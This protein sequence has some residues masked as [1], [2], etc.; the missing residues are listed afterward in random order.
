VAQPRLSQAR[1]IGLTG[2]EARC[3]ELY[4]TGHSRAEIARILGVSLR[5]VGS[6]LTG[7]K[8]KLGAKNLTHAAVL[9]T[10]GESDAAIDGTGRRATIRTFPITASRCINDPGNDSWHGAVRAEPLKPC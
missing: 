5:T 3:L 6:T 8:E 7:S 2:L 1:T 4:S 9:L 10:T